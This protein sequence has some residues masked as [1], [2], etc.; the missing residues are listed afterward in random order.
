MVIIQKRV[1]QLGNQ[2]FTMAHFAAAAVEHD[3]RVVFPCF[4]HPLKY[5]PNINSDRRFRVLQ[6]SDKMNRT[7]HRSLKLL[8][9]LAGK[10]PWHECHLAEGSP[11]M[12]IGDEDFA[13]KAR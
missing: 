4:E 12:D 8:R 9:I 11:F 1:G 5:F 6:S 10:S 13:V 3:Y 2:L 7:L